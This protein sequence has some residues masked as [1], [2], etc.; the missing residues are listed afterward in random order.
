P[1]ADG[2][3]A[4]AIASAAAAGAPG[5][6]VLN[7][8]T[9]Y[10]EV[11]PNAVLNRTGDWTVELWLK[12]EDANGF[13]H[14]DR[15]VLK[16]GD[17]VASESPYYVLLGNGSLLVGVRTAGV[18]HPLTYNLRIAG[19]SSKLWQHVAA[20]YEASAGRLRLYLNGQLVAAQVIGAA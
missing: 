5:S 6:L 4:R 3:S 2:A 1:L 13:E 15:Y 9:A 18:N 10:A 19:Y 16:K 7:G 11:A 14:E 17:G 20:V 12:D 8:T